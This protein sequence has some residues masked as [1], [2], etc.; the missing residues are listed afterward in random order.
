MIDRIDHAVSQDPVTRTAALGP[1]TS[2]PCRGP[3]GDRIEIAAYGP[4][5]D[6][7]R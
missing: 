5:A 1:T 3:D 7:R 4:V 2:I 6:A